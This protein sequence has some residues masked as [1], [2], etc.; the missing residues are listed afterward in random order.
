[1]KRDTAR[2]IAEYNLGKFKTVAHKITLIYFSIYII[3]QRIH[4][5]GHILMTSHFG[6]G[7]QGQG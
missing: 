7:V 5:Q 1:M 6:A 4:I 3:K 2:S